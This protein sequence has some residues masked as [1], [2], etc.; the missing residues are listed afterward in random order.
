MSDES[1]NDEKKTQNFHQMELDDRILKA[2]AKLGWFTPTLIQE[3]SIPL[4]LEGKDV[5]VRAK[6]G[7]GKT[8]AFAIPVIQKIL[9]SKMSATE[10]LV[11]ALV[12]APSKELCQQ[13][14]GVFDDLTIKCQRIV[15]IV[16]LSSSSNAAAIKHMLSE[17]PDIVISTPGKIL[18]QLKAQTVNL[19]D[20]LET[21]VI[22]EADLVFSFGFENDLKEVLNYLPPIYQAILASATLS[23][24]VT[25][26]KRLVLHNPVILKLEEPELAPVS[27]LTHYRILAEEDD[28]AA[29]LYSL[30]KLELIRGK[31]IIFVNTVDRC[32]K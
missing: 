18:A 9:N 24:D 17:R 4:L 2:I 20:G 25:T 26:L 29:I 16:D 6:T 3:K 13:I 8:A 32:Y 19:K 1:D 12:L 28:K 30:I 31:S 21:I 11:S 14:K 5:L 27:Q 15:R 22:D 23:E 7:S 10:Q